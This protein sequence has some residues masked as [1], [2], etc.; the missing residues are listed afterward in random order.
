M[1][2]SSGVGF[3]LKLSLVFFL[4]VFIFLISK[5]PLLAQVEQD[6]ILKIDP[7][8][9]KLFDEGKLAFNRGDFEEAFQNFKIAAFGLLDEPDLLGEAFVYLT[10][11][12]YNLKKYD[13]VEHYLKEIARFKLNSRISRSTLP[14]D[15][16]EKFNQI[17]T[18]FTKNGF[19]G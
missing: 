19:K 16:K 8:Y 13:Q 12:A 2:K 6:K 10:V 5:T 1:R 3:K 11:S 18:V 9:L 15:V 4:L 17:Q 14:E 7:F